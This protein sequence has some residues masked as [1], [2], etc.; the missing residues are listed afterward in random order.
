MKYFLFSCIKKY[1]TKEQYENIETKIVAKYEINVDE[2]EQK[3][4]IGENDSYI[5]SLIRKDSIEEFITYV[6]E[7]VI[8]LTS[9]NFNLQYLKRILI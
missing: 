6:N 7:K 5:C 1:L 9:I 3:C 2:F 4:E 8:P